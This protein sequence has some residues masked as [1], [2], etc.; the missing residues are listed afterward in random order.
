M[1][2]ITTK[3]DAFEGVG[4][5]S[6][7]EGIIETFPIDIES[8]VLGE[9]TI[10]I[11]TIFSNDVMTQ[12]GNDIAGIVGYDAINELHALLDI[13]NSQLVVP[14]R[15]NEAASYL[16]TQQQNIN[17]VPVTL[18]KSPMGFSF[19]HAIIKNRRV[20]LLVDSGAPQLVLD[21]KT[22]LDWEIIL[23][24]HPSARTVLTNGVEIPAKIYQAGKVNIGGQTITDDFFTSDFGSLMELVNVEGEP[25]LVGV[26]GNKH[27]LQ[28]G[29]VIDVKAEK[30]FI[31]E[32]R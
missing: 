24:D 26:L 27:L 6:G 14:N 4:I 28:L 5:G 19:I 11:T 17:Y 7:E 31:K 15:P 32:V 8:Y 13:P 9:H 2:G 30:V 12:F 16:E 29:S 23:A 3:N 21:E 10:D 20:R 25:P 18:S 22:L 1:F